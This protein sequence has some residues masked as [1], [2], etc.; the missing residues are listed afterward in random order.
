MALLCLL[1]I[2]TTNTLL[3]IHPV[4]EADC[5]QNQKRF[6]TRTLNFLPKITQTHKPTEFEMLLQYLRLSQ[7]WL[8]EIEANYQ[9]E[10]QSAL[11]S[12]NDTETALRNGN[13]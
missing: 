3:Q 2:N 13:F 8:A 11:D 6:F 1:K 4:G 7:E 12:I 9:D 5:P 10:K